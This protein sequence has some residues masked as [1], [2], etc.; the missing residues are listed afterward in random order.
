MEDI[1]DIVRVRQEALKRIKTAD[2]MLN[3]MYPSLQEPKILVAVLENIFLG[4][5]YSLTALLHYELNLKRIPKFKDN[6]ESKFRMF[7]NRIC[8]RYE[9]DKSFIFLLHNVKEL[10]QKHSSSPVEFSKKEKF[11]IADDKYNIEELTWEKLNSYLNK[12]IEF[13]KR[14]YKITNSKEIYGK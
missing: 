11:I 2:H 13:Y 6:F 5:T 4:L 14:I 8:L 9:F 7:R 12:S 1:D 10:V 3:V